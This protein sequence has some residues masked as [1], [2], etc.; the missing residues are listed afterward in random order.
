MMSC[1]NVSTKEGKLEL[2]S[3]PSKESKIRPYLY[4]DE[5]EPTIS[6]DSLNKIEEELDMKL[7]AIERIPE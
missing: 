3:N 6:L 7:K 5:F 1:N 2:E 4:S